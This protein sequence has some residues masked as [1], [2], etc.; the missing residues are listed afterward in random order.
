[1]SHLQD[2][3]IAVLDDQGGPS[4]TGNV[5][6]ILFE[7]RHAL[8]RLASEGEATTIDLAAIPFGPGDREELFRTLGEGEVNASL[9][10]LGETRILET[11]Y[12]G[13]WLIT[14]LSPQG[15][16]LTTQ[17][18][19]SRI[20]SLLASPEQDIRDALDTLDTYLHDQSAQES[21]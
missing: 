2:I 14:H 4:G 18:E 3:P 9:Q 11:A 21:L 5:L 19:I 10:A 12:P 6:P 7:I 15:V 13:V 20:P 16:E 1:M 8:S 17:I